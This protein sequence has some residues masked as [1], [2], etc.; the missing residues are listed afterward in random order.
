MK[1]IYEHHTSPDFQDHPA[2]R[3]RIQIYTD[4]SCPR[5][6]GPCAAG[7]LLRYQD[8]YAEYGAFQTAG[9]NNIGELEALHI[10]LEEGMRWRE[11]Y[12]PGALLHIHIDS[13]YAMGSL[14]WGWKPKANQAL[15]AT[16]KRKLG[17]AR[18]GGMVQFEWV[19]GHSNHPLND[20]ADWVAGYTV[21]LGL[22]EVKA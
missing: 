4:G 16:I 14:L 2:P 11:L 5:N 3:D 12:A 18:K 19:K 22:G 20:R 6:P 8:H 17:E 9:T 13:Q 7:V 1:R 15:I 21:R 10:A